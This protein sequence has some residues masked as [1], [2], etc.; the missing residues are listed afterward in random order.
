M[1][2]T[3]S[4][5]HTHEPASLGHETTDVDLTGAAK[6][7]VYSIAFM[8]VTFAAMWLMF[9]FFINL[10]VAKDPAPSPVAIP[11]ERLPPGPRLQTNE[12]NDLRSFRQ[13]EDAILDNYGWVDKENGIVRIPVD[14]ALDLLVERGL[15]GPAPAGTAPAPATVPPKPAQ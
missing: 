9:R 8:A 10:E 1:A 11:T 6:I 2:H 15:P 4:H 14:R 12:P 3:N 5:H 7:L 13:S